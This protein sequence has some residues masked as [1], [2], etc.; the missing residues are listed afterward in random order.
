MQR[1][2]V[3]DFENVF[4]NISIRNIERAAQ[5]LGVHPAFL[6]D[7]KIAADATPATDPAGSE[8]GGAT[9]A[10]RA[11]SSAFCGATRFLACRMA[12]FLLACDRRS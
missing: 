11:A 10:R 4:R 12:T 5:A 2:Y 1:A 9:N 3:G 6:L 8:A 7:D